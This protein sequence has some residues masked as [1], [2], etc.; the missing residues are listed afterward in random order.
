MLVFRLHCDTSALE[1]FQ[2]LPVL[3]ASVGPRDWW[4]KEEAGKVNRGES[5]MT[6]I[7]KLAQGADNATSLVEAVP[8]PLKDDGSNHSHRV[9]GRLR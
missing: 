7:S 9:Q 8:R 6:T 2:L 3:R 1:V 5:C 4:K